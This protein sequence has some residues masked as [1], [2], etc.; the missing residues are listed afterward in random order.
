MNPLSQI[1][2]SKDAL[3]HNF[4]ALKDF[5]GKGVKMAPCIKANAYGHGLLEC[6]KV[7]SKA[8]ADFLC[9]N[10]LFE[11]EALRKAGIKT[12]LLVLGYTPL[13]DL[14][15][16]VK[17][18]ADLTIY[19]LETLQALK[20]LKKPVNVHLKVE[21]GIHRQGVYPKDLPAILKFLKGAKTIKLQGVSMHF[22]NVEDAYNLEFAQIQLREF[23]SAL[24]IIEDAGFKPPFIHAAASAAAMLMPEARFNM[25][26][27]GI[28]T[29]GLWPSQRTKD[30]L[31]ER[32][33]SLVLKPVLT[34]RTQVA[35][36]KDVKAGAKIGYGCT[37]E[38]PQ[39]GR[40]AIVPV[41]YYD[42]YV[43]LLG[44]KADVLI[45]GRRAA[46]L[47]RVCMN[48][49][50]VNITEI[51]NTELEDDV[52]LLGRMGSEMVSADELASKSGTI[53][54]EVTTRLNERI[55]RVLV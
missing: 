12:P 10:A 48:I 31:M 2:I 9:I 47:G 21:T 29:Y 1:E 25:V 50:M 51:P 49:I 4:K 44:G 19:N 39:D 38:M 5:F 53:N 28:A 33:Q 3:T 41:G 7:L 55:P 36:I 42:G 30:S 14:G 32:G 46:V 17:L 35:Q 13:E 45:H 6:A 27:P 11:A 22:A 24:K 52:I 54:Y 23:L 18:K 16:A 15:A 20:K 40:I 43:R 8:G 26:R 34:W 37:Y